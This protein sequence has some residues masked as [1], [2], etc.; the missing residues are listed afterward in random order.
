VPT[1]KDGD[2]LGTIKLQTLGVGNG[3]TLHNTKKD[4][5]LKKKI[6]HWLEKSPIRK[7]LT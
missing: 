3:D 2:G 7:A 6:K 1:V 5:D 4:L